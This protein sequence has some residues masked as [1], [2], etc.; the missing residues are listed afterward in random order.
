[1]DRHLVVLFRLD[2]DFGIFTVLFRLELN[3]VNLLLSVLVF[4]FNMAGVDF[5][6]ASTSVQMNPAEV[7]QHL[8]AGISMETGYEQRDMKLK[9][10]VTEQSD[11][12]ACATLNE[13]DES[14]KIEFV[15]HEDIMNTAD[16][17]DLTC[18][19]MLQCSTRLLHHP[20]R[21]PRLLKDPSSTR[22]A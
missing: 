14:I 7:T 22:M 1:M 18:R 9:V 10:N 20:H 16:W 21:L 11:A 19:M 3:F 15:M 12:S 4:V 2:Q 5:A 13:H 6:S 17:V 8:M